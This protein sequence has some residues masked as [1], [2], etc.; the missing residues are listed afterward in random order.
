M[1]DE[2]DFPTTRDLQP[3]GIG[4]AA[5]PVEMRI[6]REKQEE[7]LSAAEV[8]WR[9]VLADPV[10]RREVWQLLQAAHTFEERFACGPNGFPQPEATWFHA[11]EQSFGQRFYQKLQFVDREGVWLMQDEH[12]PRY[13]RPPSTQ[14]PR[15]RS[16]KS[17]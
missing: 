11:G 15:R 8:F 13:A 14:K 1:I 4:N 9:G 10:G 6:A 7:R 2:D 3:E 16:R 5:D 12:D 17:T